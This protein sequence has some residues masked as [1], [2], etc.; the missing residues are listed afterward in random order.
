[1][2][3]QTLRLARHFARMEK[4]CGGGR[5]RRGQAEKRSRRRGRG[6]R[7]GR[8]PCIAAHNSHAQLF[9]GRRPALRNFQI[10]VSIKRSGGRKERRKEG[11]RLARRRTRTRTR[12][13]AAWPVKFSAPSPSLFWSGRTDKGE[14][15][16][17]A[18]N[19]P[20]IYV[21]IGRPQHLHPTRRERPTA[22]QP[23]VRQTGQG[24]ARPAS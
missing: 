24:F 6:E 3:G 21:A 13:P 7:I 12:R 4:Y 23:G 8:L 1:M 5:R 20:M 2:T 11:V 15:R 22:G 16:A 14:R 17:R 10:A 19:A 18:H 9:L